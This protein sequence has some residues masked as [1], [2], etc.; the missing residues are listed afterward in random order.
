M[1]RTPLVVVLALLAA[2]ALAPPAAG[3]EATGYVMDEAGIIPPDVEERIEAL[4]ARVE[5]STPGAQ[6]AVVTVASL[7]GRSIEEYAERVFDE[8][9]I[10]S[11]DLDNG[12]LLIVAVSEREVRIEVGYGLEGAIPDPVAGRVLDED[13]IP[14]FRDGDMAAGI[15][16]GHAR[17]AGLVAAEYETEVEGATAPRR[18]SGMCLWIGLLIGAGLIW[19]FVWAAKK[20]MLKGG[21]GS[22]GS[23][24]GFTPP[25]PST[26]G[27][28][29]SSSSWGG[30]SSGGGFGGFGGGGSGGGG[31]SRGW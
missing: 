20:G 12:V 1:R 22:G 15:E 11:K 19:L 6:I 25:P 5:T 27:G 23:G 7:D 16:A 29:S 14:R 4:S 21:G 28:S 2:L 31:A 30:G 9:G 13:V 17:I 24:G 18:G 26:W 8:L 10:G 3:I